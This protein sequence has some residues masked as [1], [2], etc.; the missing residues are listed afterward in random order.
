[1]RLSGL[2]VPC[3]LAKTDLVGYGAGVAQLAERLICNA[4]IASG[5]RMASN[6]GI[7][8]VRGAKCWLSV[9]PPFSTDRPVPRRQALTPA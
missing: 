8:R 5:G 7:S 4:V 2:S 3:C 6:G 9:Y 1:V